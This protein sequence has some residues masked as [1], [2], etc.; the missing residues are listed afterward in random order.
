MTQ[1]TRLN[2]ERF[3]KPR[4]ARAENQNQNFS[5][6]G[7]QAFATFE[8]AQ[9]VARNQRR[10]GKGTEAYRCESC[11]QYHTGRSSFSTRNKRP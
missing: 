4:R 1:G 7:K 5:C 6:G 2:F 10:L 11:G 9:K 8:H 3:R